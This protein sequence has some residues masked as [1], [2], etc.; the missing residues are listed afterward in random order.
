MAEGDDGYQ[1]RVGPD[2]YTW[3]DALAASENLN[4]AGHSDWRLPDINELRSLVDYSRT[5]RTI[6]PV[7]RL[8]LN[9]PITGRLLSTR[10]IRATRGS[11][12]STMAA[13]ARPIVRMP[14]M[15]IP[16]MCVQFRGEQGIRQPAICMRTSLDTALQLE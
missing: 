1:E 3:Q 11:S 15:L 7:L 4:L 14:M 10:A 6:D 9:R 5:N 2:T 16:I 12:V 8:R 13:T